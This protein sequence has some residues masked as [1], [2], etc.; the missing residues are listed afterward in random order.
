MIDNSGLG[1]VRSHW[2]LVGIFV[3]FLFW[4]G[5]VAMAG[6]AGGFGYGLGREDGG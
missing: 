3:V 1:E 6:A 2:N 4:E 5:Q